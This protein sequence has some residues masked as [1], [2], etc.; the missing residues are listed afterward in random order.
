MLHRPL[1]YIDRRSQLMRSTARVVSSPYVDLAAGSNDE[2]RPADNNEENSLTPRPS[3]HTPLEAFV[4]DLDWDEDELI[5]SAHP[6]LQ[7]PVQP[8]SENRGEVQ[9]T[10]FRGQ[11]RVDERSPLLPRV[12]EAA[13][14]PIAERHSP[15]SV[16]IKSATIRQSTFSQTVR[17][18]VF[19]E[20]RAI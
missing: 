4:S 17:Q 7:Q 18:A 12:T 3:A 19:S 1:Y 13:L 20:V 6:S 11:A 2:P 8:P 16:P 14:Q 9:A 15:S 5:I 10:I